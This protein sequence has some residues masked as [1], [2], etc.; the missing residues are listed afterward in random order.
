M[1]TS[2]FRAG[3]TLGRIVCIFVVWLTIFAIMG[4]LLWSGERAG[5]LYS[6]THN[7][8]DRISGL[9][10]YEMKAMIRSEKDGQYRNVRS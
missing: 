1:V 4:V 5:L 3:W 8:F 10:Y 9:P 7:D 2:L 6:A